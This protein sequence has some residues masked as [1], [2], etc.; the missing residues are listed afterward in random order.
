MASLDPQLNQFVGAAGSLAVLPND[1]VTRKLAMLLDG[2]CNGLGPLEAAKK[3]GFSK[4]RYF[5]IRHAFA[6]F[7]SLALTSQKRGP[8]RNYRRTDE[9]VRQI[10]R[11]RFLDPE[12]SADVIAQKLRQTGWVISTRSVERSLAYYGLQKKTPSLPSDY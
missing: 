10:I 4:Q 9:V 5:Q 11:H 8:K 3:F 2:E 12:A 6:E 1:E 7:G